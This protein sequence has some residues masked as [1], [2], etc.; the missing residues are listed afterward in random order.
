M[1][2]TDSDQA[3]IAGR[4]WDLVV[5]GGG[6][7]GIVT[8]RTAASLGARVALVERARTGGDCL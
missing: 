5:I 1:T 7:A 8:S 4:P 6:T 3:A 2:L